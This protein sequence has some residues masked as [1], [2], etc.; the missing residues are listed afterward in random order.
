MSLYRALVSFSGEKAVGAPGQIVEI[1]HK[2]TE[3][4]LLKIG[5]IQKLSADDEK[6]EVARREAEA[7]REAAAEEA[8]QKAADEEPVA[9]REPGPSAAE[10]QQALNDELKPAKTSKSAGKETG[11]PEEATAAYQGAE[12]NQQDAAANPKPTV[13]AVK[14]GQTSQ[15]GVDVTPAKDANSTKGTTQGDG[16]PAPTVPEEQADRNQAAVKAQA[17]ADKTAAKAATENAE[18]GPVNPGAAVTLPPASESEAA[19]APASTTNKTPT[20]T[21]KAADQA[22]ATAAAKKVTR[23]TSKK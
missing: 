22:K 1:N 12:T 15:G 5:Y 21:Q 3:K 14:S 2:A 23:P 16:D 18:H 8:R 19:P 11:T 6:A 20:N 4:D 13:N 9:P 10:T 7:E 17:E